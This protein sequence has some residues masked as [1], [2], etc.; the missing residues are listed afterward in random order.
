[1]T[2]MVSS[3]IKHRINYFALR[4]Q[5]FQ[6]NPLR[7][8]TRS[9]ENRKAGGQPDAGGGNAWVWAVLRVLLAKWKPWPFKRI[10][11]IGAHVV[12]KEDEE[13][14]TWLKQ[15]QFCSDKMR[16][17]WSRSAKTAPWCPEGS[18]GDW[19]GTVLHLGFCLLQ[20]RVALRLPLPPQIQEWSRGTVSGVIRSIYP[21]P[22][23][24]GG[25][26]HLRASQ[27]RNSFLPH[28]PP[29]KQ[30]CW[31]V[32]TESQSQNRPR[33]QRGSCDAE[34]LWWKEAGL[35]VKPFSWQLEAAAAAKTW[36]LW[37]G[38]WQQS[39]PWPPVLSGTMV[40]GSDITW[41]VLWPEFGCGLGFT[42]HVPILAQLLGL[43]RSGPEDTRSCPI[44]FQ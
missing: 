27:K 24:I 9:P 33:F 30:G 36:T 38:R 11:S 20:D 40:D 21:F 1:M 34:R 32:T 31:P 4:K 10:K 19:D 16:E 28:Q 3:D 17:L 26:P 22:T 6:V 7:H 18:R 41:L 12:E 44:L 35:V 29:L 15:M 2:L 14:I 8:P 43:V 5:N 39:K 13:A 37:G 23:F 25:V 42:P